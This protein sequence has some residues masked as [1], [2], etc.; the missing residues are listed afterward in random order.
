[1]PITFELLSEEFFS[2]GQHEDYYDEL[3]KLGD[4]LRAEILTALRDIAFD[5]VAWEIAK[6]ERVTEK[7]LLRHITR[8]TVLG[9]FR[10]MSRGYARLTRYSFSYTPPK[11]E[12]DNAA[13]V[14][15]DFHV[16][17]ESPLPSNVH[18]LIGRNG[19]GKTRFLELM[20]KAVV[21]IK[22]QSEQSGKFEFLEYSDEEI[23]TF[24]NVVAVGFSWFDTRRSRLA[25]RKP[26]GEKIGYSFI[27]LLR[28]EAPSESRPGKGEMKSPGGSIAEF[29]KSFMECQWPSRNQ[30]W[31][32]ILKTLESDP[33]IRDA[34]L[35]FW[36][37]LTHSSSNSKTEELTT[38]FNRLSS[39]HKI[40][41]L[42]LVRLVELVEERT[43]VLIDEPESHLHPPLLSAMIRAISELMIAKNGVAIVATHSPVVLQEVPKNC[44]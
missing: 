24:A 17:P 1:M 38:L 31:G 39:G 8:T 42:T 32:R 27:G 5:D 43:L 28:F 2:L 18:V 14:F 34:D 30:I 10:R 44:V 19:V 16:D 4:E 12:L 22:R 36:A 25:D 3:L 20:A 37:G 15:L 21:G 9:Q 29:T 13:D 33:I 40:V 6:N 26:D 7:S 11:H 35:W 23:G 41:L